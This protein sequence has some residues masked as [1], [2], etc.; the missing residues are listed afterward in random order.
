[1]KTNGKPAERKS[2][3]VLTGNDL[4]AKDVHKI[5]CASTVSVS[6][7]PS[8]D[9][10]VRRSRNFVESQLSKQVTYGVNTGFGPMAS[11][12]I[13]KDKLTELQLNLI[14]SHAVGMGEPLPSSFVRGIMAVRLN[15]L[16]KGYSGVS[17]E[18]LNNLAALVNSGITPI[19]PEH[20]A[21]GT[22]GDLVQLAHIALA[23]IGEGEVEYKGKRMAAK[24]AFQAAGI[25]PY[26]VK[27]KEGLSLING[28]SAMTAIAAIATVAAERAIDISIKNGAWA[29]ELVS[30]FD[31]C[32][33][34]ALSAVRPHPGQVEVAERLGR[35]LAS[36]KL[37]QNRKQFSHENHVTKKNHTIPEEV[38][39]V[40]SLRCIPQIVGPIL[41]TLKQ[42]TA[43]VEREMNSASDNPI[44][45]DYNGELEF[46]HG[47][48]FHGDYIALAADTLKI[49]IGKLTILSERRLNYFL[50]QKINQQFPPFLNLNEPGITLA[51]QGLQFVATST[52]A[53]SQ[54][55]GFPQYL[56][57]ISTNADNQD[58]VSMGMEAALFL[59]RMLR[60]AFTV[61][62]IESLALAQATD[63]LKTLPKHAADTQEMYRLI[64]KEI[65]KIVEDRVLVYEL[66]KLQRLIEGGTLP[67]F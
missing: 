6:I 43:T 13:A 50:N 7:H 36:S 33:S 56:H 57:S 67:C 27:P 17:G 51:L 52:T 64:R 39:N 30:G 49:A 44:V 46:L 20:G 55:L 63:V 29:L 3:I 58:V 66:P 31:D 60:N 15:T 35:I 45:T 65:P 40:Y 38:Q 10:R 16:T 11:H 41:D 25:V 37:I 1:M 24:E 47:G 22:S 9:E 42:T 18:L 59:I 61:L 2:G 34:K 12:I 48:N 23:L 19:I 14:R 8:A 54:T 5:A 28:T 21:V 53:Q 26:A 32:Y 62:S 4:Q